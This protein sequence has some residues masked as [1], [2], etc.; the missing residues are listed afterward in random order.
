MPKETILIL[1]KEHNI[2]WTL[3]ALLESE[4]YLPLV[5]STTEKALNH[6]SEYEVAGLITEYWIDDFCTLEVIR[7]LKK[8]F[9]EVYVNKRRGTGFQN[10]EEPQ[11]WSRDQNGHFERTR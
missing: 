5:A 6:F 10:G 9:P 7:D 11:G 1:E 2:Q 4:N 8:R 3:K